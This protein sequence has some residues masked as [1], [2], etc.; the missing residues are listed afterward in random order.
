[1]VGPTDVVQPPVARVARARDAALWAVSSA[2]GARR[3]GCAAAGVPVF[4]NR[5][6]DRRALRGLA[7]TRREAEGLALRVVELGDLEAAH[8]PDHP[9]RGDARVD[10]RA[11]A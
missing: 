6:L 9:R 10:R 1:M 8:A 3:C 7:R 2:G 4:V 11:D 5:L